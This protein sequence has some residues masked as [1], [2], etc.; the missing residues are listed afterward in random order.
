MMASGVQFDHLA[1]FTQQDSQRNVVGTSFGMS[2]P[3]AGVGSTLDTPLPP[4]QPLPVTPVP[5]FYTCLSVHAIAHRGVNARA[6]WNR[7]CVS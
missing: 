2:P 4:L 6:R 7:L 5:Y 1:D 3:E